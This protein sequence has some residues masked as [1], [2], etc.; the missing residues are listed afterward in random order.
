MPDLVR[1][2]WAK[3]WNLCPVILT[4]FWKF[5]SGAL[6][7]IIRGPIVDR[8]IMRC[9]TPLIFDVHDSDVAGPGATLNNDSCTHDVT[10]MSQAPVPCLP[11]T[12]IMHPVFDF[13]YFL[14]NV[15]YKVVG[16]I[17]QPWSAL[18]VIP[19]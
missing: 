12:S 19:Y 9:L 5:S 16:Y 4:G 17:M 11:C 14:L 7:P 1:T 18:H 3:T 15:T 10:L 2:Y 8:M 6:S 13:K